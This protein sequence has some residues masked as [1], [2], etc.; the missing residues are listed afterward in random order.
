MKKIKNKDVD[1]LYKFFDERNGQ[2]IESELEVLGDKYFLFLNN[3]ES[4][5]A[6]IKQVYWNYIERAVDWAKQAILYK[7]E[8]EFIRSLPDSRMKRL[9]YAIFFTK[10]YHFH[11]SGWIKFDID[12]IRFLSNLTN[13]K[14]EDL[15]DLAKYGFSVRVAGKERPTTTFFDPDVMIYGSLSEF[16]DDDIVGFVCKCDCPASFEDFIDVTD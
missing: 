11:C 10:K 5:I 8:V 13:V 6:T 2:N 3:K 9:F 7:K 14:L 1:S 16:Y 4:R 15:A 12:E